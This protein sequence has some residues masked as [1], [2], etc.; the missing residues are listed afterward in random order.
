[1]PGSPIDGAYSNIVGLNTTG[2]YYR[3]ED[4]NTDITLSGDLIS[5]I[6]PR[7]QFK[8]GFD[9]TYYNLNRFQEGKAY[10]VFE[11]AVYN[12]FEGNLY[13][14]S[15]LEF[16]GLIVNVGLRFDFYNPNDYVYLNPFD[17]FGEIAAID[18]GTAANPEREK[19]TI[20]GQLSPE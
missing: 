1:M 3:G 17:P 19:T 12:P 10:N 18:N 16:E 7:W 5:Q 4:K 8:S 6:N 2:Y 15:K 11:R 20:F 9:L 13:A 14:Q